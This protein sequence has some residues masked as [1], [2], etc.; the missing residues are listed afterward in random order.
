MTT[1]EPGTHRCPRRGES[2][3]GRTDEELPDT[4]RGTSMVNGWAPG[5]S[6][7][8]SVSGDDFMTF[9]RDGHSVQGTD[10]SYKA[11]VPKGEQNGKFYFQHLSEEQRVEFVELFNAGR[12][13]HDLYVLPFFMV[14]A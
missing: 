13:S 14:L 11:Y 3:W 2:G 8:G 6:Y 10:K 9:V 5:C 4:Y 12:V 7:C 1:S